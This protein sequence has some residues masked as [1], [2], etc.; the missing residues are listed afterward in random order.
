MYTFNFCQIHISNCLVNFSSIQGCHTLR[1]LREFSSYRKP[2][3]NS[4]N[5]DHFF[6]SGKLRVVLV[7]S[8]NCREIIR[9]L[10]KS[11]GNF[12]LDLELD[13]VNPVLI[14]CSKRLILF[15][16][17]CLFRIF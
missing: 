9:F 1:E 14:F 4:G 12:F 5:F 2:Q 6:N 15:I 16:F 7:Y 17:K 3:G 13:L 11:Q 10:K 8:K